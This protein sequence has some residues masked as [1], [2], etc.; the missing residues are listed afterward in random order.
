MRCWA[1]RVLYYLVSKTHVHLVI[2]NT[3]FAHVLLYVYYTFFVLSSV[4]YAR[5][6]PYDIFI[7]VYIHL[8]SFHILKIIS[9]DFFIYSNL[10]SFKFFLE[11]HTYFSIY[12]CWIIY[13]CVLACMHTRAHSHFDLF[14]VYVIHMLMY[15]YFVSY[16]YKYDD[17]SYFISHI[18][19]FIMNVN[20]KNIVAFISHVT[21]TYVDSFMFSVIRIWI[22]PYWMIS[23]ECYIPVWHMLYIYIYKCIHIHIYICIYIY[24]YIHI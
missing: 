6:L 19:W 23:Y 1:Y 3:A 4:K 7:Y 17:F 5:A 14:V 8:E 22:Y 15:S 21:Y 20:H 9:Y 12:L 11:F 18:Y 2:Y 24:I 16:A 13:A 10:E